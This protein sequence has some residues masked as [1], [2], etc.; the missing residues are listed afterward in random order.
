[1]GIFKP[2]LLGGGYRE[3]RGPG[4]HMPAGCPLSPEQ[5][6]SQG[7]AQ[8]EGLW[9]ALRVHSPRGAPV[10]RTKWEAV[11]S[12]AHVWMRLTGPVSPQASTQALSRGLPDCGPSEPRP[13]PACMHGMEQRGPGLPVQA[14]ERG[15]QGRPKSP[16]FR[17]GRGVRRPLLTLSTV[18]SREEA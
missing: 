15:R 6:P 9:A 16:R 4:G 12:L 13:G 3:S 11:E 10:P 8:A 17:K 1:M 14:P 2:R 5:S 7:P 18:L